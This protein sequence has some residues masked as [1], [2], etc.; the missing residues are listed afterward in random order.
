MKN[1]GQHRQG[2]RSRVET[3][4][5]HPLGAIGKTIPIGICSPPA[6]GM[7]ER[8]RAG[9]LS[10]TSP[11]SSCVAQ[12]QWHLWSMVRKTRATEASN[13]LVEVGFRPYPNGLGTN[14]HKGQ[15]PS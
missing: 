4:V 3:G 14:V 12:G 9:S 15:V 2:R 10:R 8:E 11:M 1:S 6:G 5:L 7:M 13:Q